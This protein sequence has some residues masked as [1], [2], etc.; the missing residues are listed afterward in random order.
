[1]RKPPN[2]VEFA[3]A[4]AQAPGIEPPTRPWL[5]TLRAFDGLPLSDD[6]VSILCS[7]TGRSRK[8]IRAHEGQPYPSSGRVLGDVGARAQQRQ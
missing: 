2:L 1:M 4:L 3:L 8:A 5:A 6:D 7:V